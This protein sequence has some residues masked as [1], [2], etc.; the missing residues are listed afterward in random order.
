MKKKLYG[1]SRVLKRET[2]ATV[3]FFFIELIKQI[4][5]KGVTWI[6]S[7][8]ARGNDVAQSTSEC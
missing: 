4:I 1:N 6:A 5:V 3:E 7:S 8:R 2:V